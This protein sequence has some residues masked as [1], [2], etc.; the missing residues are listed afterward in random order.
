M[1][2]GVMAASG[3]LYRDRSVSIFRAGVM[4][5]AV[6]GLSFAAQLRDAEAAGAEPLRAKATVDRFYQWRNGALAWTGLANAAVWRDLVSAIGMAE[7]HGLDPADYRLAELAAA[8]PAAGDAQLDRIA[9]DAYLT[10]AAHLLSGRLDPVSIEPNWTAAPRERDLA[11]YLESALANGAVAESLDALAP[12][13]RGYRDLQRALAHYRVIAE[14][15]GWPAIDSGPTLRIGDRGRRVAQLRRR[16]ATTGDITGA[17]SHPELFDEALAEAVRRFQKRTNLEPDGTV[18]PRTLAQLNTSVAERI[19]Q[20]RANMERWR[21]LPD[22]LGRRHV[23]VNIADY[24]LEAHANGRVERMHEIIVG[25][26]YRKTPIFTG[27]MTYLVL[28][29]WWETPPNLAVKDKLPVFR[30]DPNSVETLGFQVIDRNGAQVDAKTIDWNAV[31]ERAF[32]YRIR[33][34]PGPNNALGDVKFMFPNRHNVYLHDTPTRGLFARTRRDFSSG[35]VRVRDAL[36][37]ADWVLAETPGWDRA[38]IRV[39]A[40]GD[41]ETLVRLAQPIPV[42]ILYWTVVSDG[43]DTVRFLD[44][45]YDRDARLIAAL[46]R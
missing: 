20:I 26:L 23:R 41:E 10:L 9:T 40:A 36:E 8:S 14:K 21:W 30:R 22:D 4:V 5:F 42:H 38:R 6:L 31:P 15:G 12:T 11:A 28:N 43:A 16:L 34:A 27:T 13:Q 18:G 37:F 44:D 1:A 2:M 35:C 3:N 29:P 7:L 46:D 17:A 19:A 24:R 39:L 32:P 33:Q 45:I 25:R